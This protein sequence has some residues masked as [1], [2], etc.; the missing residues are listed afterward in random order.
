M[1]AHL[2]RLLGCFIGRRKSASPPRAFQPLHRFLKK[3]QLGPNTRD[4]R[5]V[6][7]RKPCPADGRFPLIDA[8]VVDVVVNLRLPQ[9][10]RTLRTLLPQRSFQISI[11]S[12]WCAP[13]GGPDRRLSQCV[14]NVSSKAFRTFHG[15]ILADDGVLKLA[16]LRRRHDGRRAARPAPPGFPKSSVHRPKSTAVCRNHRQSRLNFHTLRHPLPRRA[17]GALWPIQAASGRSA[18]RSGGIVIRAAPFLRHLRARCGARASALAAAPWRA[19]AMPR[20]PWRRGRHCAYCV[21]HS[22]RASRAS[23]PL[24][25]PPF[26]PRPSPADHARR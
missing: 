15:E 4:L 23:H 1:R 5:E 8:H 10:F 12:V 9:R 14:N 13:Q 2:S 26:R 24:R 11:L 17:Q 19:R 22:H 6:R 7:A 18:L 21:R 3:P 16:S 25:P 20:G